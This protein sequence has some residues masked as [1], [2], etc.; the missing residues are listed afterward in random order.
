MAVRQMPLLRN[1]EASD[2]IDKA[3]DDLADW[4]TRAGS[5]IDDEL[6]RVPDEHQQTDH[7]KQGRALVRELHELVQEIEL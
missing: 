5:W 4:S 3:L 6:D 1:R 7:V 2:A